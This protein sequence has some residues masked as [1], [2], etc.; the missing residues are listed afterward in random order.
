[1]VELRSQW[2]CAPI[3]TDRD[4][5]YISLYSNWD[6]IIVVSNGYK[7]TLCNGHIQKKCDFFQKW[8]NTS[9][10]NYTTITSTKVWTTHVLSI[11]IKLDKYKH[12][13]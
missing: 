12:I 1:M 6:F 9:E 13:W 4:D 3:H 8:N 10:S 5:T 11:W 7:T 2:Q